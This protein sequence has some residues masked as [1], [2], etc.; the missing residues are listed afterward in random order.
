MKKKVRRIFAIILLLFAVFNVTGI[1]AEELTEETVIED[2]IGTSTDASAAYGELTGVEQM[3]VT[4]SLVSQ[5]I[6][7]NDIQTMDMG[8]YVI[9]GVDN[10]Q[11]SGAYFRWQAY[12]FSKGSW[13]MFHDWTTASCVFWVP[14]HVGDYYLYVEAMV[15]GTIVSSY[16]ELHYFSGCLTTLG[17]ISFTCGNDCCSYD[18]AYTT[19]DSEL[20]FRWLAYDVSTGTWYLIRDW[21]D[22]SNG[23]WNP[24]HAGDYFLYVEAKGGDGSIKTKLLV[25]HADEP[26]IT[27]FTQN[28]S[29]GY[30]NE[31][32]TLAGTYSDSTLSIGTQRYLVYDG[33]FWKV[34]PHEGGQA[35][36]K[37][38]QE[39]GYLLCYEI[40]DKKG[41]CVEQRFQGFEI[42][43]PYVRLSDMKV[44]HPD[45]LEYSLSA[46]IDTND[47]NIQYRWQYY[48]IVNDA[49]HIISDWSDSVETD[50]TAP[51]QGY[52]WLHLEAKL[53]DG[54]I[55]SLTEG[56]VTERIESEEQRMC[57]LANAYS[58]DTNYLVLVN[59]ATHKVGIFTG[60]KGNWQMNFYWDCA[61][62][63]ESTPTVTGVF[64]VGKKGYYFDSDGVRCYYYT[65]FYKGYLFHSVLYNPKNGNLADGRVGM[66]LSHG[67]V[68]LQIDNA[69]WI[70]DNIPKGTTVVVYN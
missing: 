57:N 65:Q 60:S 26:Y 3:E 12:D 68:R 31:D 58:S 66:A 30:I 19:N 40:Y 10:T 69:K 24:Y 52:Y 22:D 32:V 36:W 48:D 70:Y 61:D 62:G 37:P 59:R 27:S 4:N 25:C 9:V 23:Q 11:M 63:K 49:W 2:T 41:N 47:T 17:D 51:D 8:R 29:Y 7:I 64:T 34:I 21:S 53:R 35:V 45:Q 54:S 43:K 13:V 18:V 56:I 5:N 50:W 28:L 38:E 55:Q 44:E 1:K 39:G 6:E 14:E 20:M 46:T 42:K 67:C 15:N 33:M 16:A